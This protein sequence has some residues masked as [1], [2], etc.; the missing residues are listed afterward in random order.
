MSRSYKKTP[1]TKR[2]GVMKD[3]Y[4]RTVR[5]RTKNILRS[6]DI[7]ELDEDGLP[8]PKTIINDYNYIDSINYDE[9][10]LKNKRK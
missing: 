6:K 1:V 10:N 9:D 7:E 2:D 8:D 3:T 4:W 5:S